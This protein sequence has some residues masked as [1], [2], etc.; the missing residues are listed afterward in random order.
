M[1]TTLAFCLAILT[2]LFIQGQT[3]WYP[4]ESNTIQDLRCIDFVDSS[5]GF[6]AGDSVLI[7]TIDGGITWNEVQIDSIAVNNWQGW[8][9][10]DI[11]FFTELH[12]R[13]VLGQWGG[14]VETF[15]G[16]ANWSIITPLSSGFCQFGS[17][18]FQDADNGFIGGAG[19]FESAIIERYEA[20][21][22]SFTELPPTWDTEDLVNN[23][24]FIDADNGLACTYL[25]RILRTT[26]GGS[27]WDSIPNPVTPGNITDIAYLT[28]DSVYA[29]YAYANDNGVLISLDGGLTW[30]YDWE[31][32]TFFTP[33]MYAAHVSNSGRAYFAGEQSF[34][35]GLGIAYNHE[36]SF[37]NYTLLPHAIRDIDSY[38]E[39]ITF[40]V[41][42][43]G[44]VFTNTELVPLSTQKMP[45]QFEV[46]TWPNPTS[47]ILNVHTETKFSALSYKVL[48]LQGKQVAQGSLNQ[49]GSTSFSVAYFPAGEYLLEITSKD[50]AFA[51]Q[52]FQK[53]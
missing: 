50:G 8:F 27:T 14:M 13:M 7:K 21:I 48:D 40:L 17:F 15:D 28:A 24:D 34:D 41:G 6:A 35:D 25:G 38:G 20:G 26:D 18:F 29:T 9:A 49:T 51:V 12:G 31:S 4:I 43:S 1:K 16:G 10:Y 11:Q 30:D 45:I 42:D 32:F 23:F 36:G 52:K 39:D 46:K 53:Y 47:D 19:C 5:I 37:L 22:F 2:S 44:A 33:Q 3:E